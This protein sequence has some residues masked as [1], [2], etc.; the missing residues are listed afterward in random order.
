MGL[1]SSCTA[2]F[3]GNS[4]R[5]KLLLESDSLLFRGDFRLKIPFNSMRSVK[6]SPATLRITFPDGTVAFD[7]GTAAARWADKILHPK[8]LLDKLGVNPSSVVSVLGMSDKDFLRQL[9]ACASAVTTGKPAPSSDFLFLAAETPRALGALKKLP[10][11]LQPAGAIWVIY[12][13][14]QPHITEADVMAAAKSAGLVDVKVCS[15]SSSHTALKL[16]IPVSRR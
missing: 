6:A 8:S 11:S 15:F 10:A 13:K 14:G 9:R 4:A 2:H 3:K 16:V 7:L 1:E 12:P 5:G